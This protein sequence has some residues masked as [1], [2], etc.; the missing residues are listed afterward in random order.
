MLKRIDLN[1]KHRNTGKEEIEVSKLM[2]AP[3]IKFGM[4]TVLSYAKESSE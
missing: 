2:I 1:S 3:K 4:L